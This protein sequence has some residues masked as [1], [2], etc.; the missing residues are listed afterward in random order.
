MKIKLLIKSENI[1]IRIRN[2][3]LIS[4]DRSLIFSLAL[5][6]IIRD[7]ADNPED[8]E[9]RM[10]TEKNRGEGCFNSRT[11]FSLTKEEKKEEGR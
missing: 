6:V 2:K 8:E 3:E 1:E 4:N 11:D 7:Y 5:S 9:W 10:T